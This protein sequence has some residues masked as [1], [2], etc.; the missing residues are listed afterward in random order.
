MLGQISRTGAFVAALTSVVLVAGVTA[1]P[2][3][4]TLPV[5]I[6]CPKDGAHSPC[7]RLRVFHQG[8]HPPNV[9]GAQSW[10]LVRHV[11]LRGSLSGAKPQ[12]FRL[13]IENATYSWGGAGDLGPVAYLGRSPGNRPVIL[14]RA[15]PLEILSPGFDVPRPNE[16]AWIGNVERE[17]VTLKQVR[18]LLPRDVN[19]GMGSDA[20]VASHFGGMGTGIR[21]LRIKGSETLIVSVARDG[22]C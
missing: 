3:P 12:I 10:D 4:R 8:K 17:H 11:E 20:D 18:R 19:E 9:P 16:F 5:E 1:A 14:T 2:A 22:G 13:R 7:L 6:H 21:I 15:G